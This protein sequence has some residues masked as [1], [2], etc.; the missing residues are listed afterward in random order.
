MS[1]HWHNRAILS[2]IL[3]VEKSEHPCIDS[4]DGRCHHLRPILTGY[5][6]TKDSISCISAIEDYLELLNGE[7][8]TIVIMRNNPGV[9]VKG[10]G[11]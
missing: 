1:E 6:E 5:V 2:G 9:V 4:E 8:V 3:R 10:D 7:D 11:Q